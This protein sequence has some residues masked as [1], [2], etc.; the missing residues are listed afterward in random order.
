[1]RAGLDHLDPTALVVEAL[2]AAGFSAAIA[3]RAAAVAVDRLLGDDV[4][5]HLVRRIDGAFSEAFR[6]WN[7]RDDIYAFPG[8]P[9][10]GS[11]V[12]VDAM[13]H[14]LGAGARFADELDS[15]EVRRVLA[16]VDYRGWTFE[17]EHEPPLPATVVVTAT[18]DNC[19][20][21]GQT[22]TLSRSAPI[23]NGDVRAAVLDAVLRVEEHEAAERLVIGG[24]RPFN[25][26]APARDEVGP[27][28]L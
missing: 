26:H 24:A 4:T 22:F 3:E 28:R 15:D 6:A 19:H 9:E 14:A 17:L 11:R 13:R 20:K 21:D 8:A 12:A 16:T 10:T 23:R 5:E 7:L 1:M 27:Q 2:V 25:P 18:V